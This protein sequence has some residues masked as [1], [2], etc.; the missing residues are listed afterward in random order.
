MGGG[1]A[2]YRFTL[3]RRELIYA[4]TFGTAW[5]TKLFLATSCITP[6]RA[7]Q[8]LGDL[9][10]DDNLGPGCTTGGT[11][12]QIYTVLNPG[13]YYL[14]VSSN[15]TP[16]TATIRFE[17]LNV[18]TGSVALLGRG[19]TV[20]AGTTVAGVASGYTSSC[21]GSGPEQAF[22]WTTC[23]EQTAGTLNATTC[24]RAT[25]NTVLSVVSGGGSGDLCND[26]STTCGPQSTLTSTLA[27]GSGLHALI[28]DGFGGAAGTYTVLVTRP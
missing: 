23:P 25:W 12:S 26:T 17:H 14:V 3:T 20:R 21:G 13:T 28:V 24:S 2:F 11:A 6:L 7:S 8:T 9:I 16:S 18:G 4:D 22:W 1:D 5:D 15:G 27:A 10:C 19:T